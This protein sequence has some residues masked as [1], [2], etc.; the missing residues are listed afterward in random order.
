MT[1]FEALQRAAREGRLPPVVLLHGPE[2]LLRRRGLD[3]IVG[4]NRAVLVKIEGTETH[5]GRVADEL[6]GRSLFDPARVVAVMH[7]EEFI[8]SYRQRIE[9]YAEHPA[10]K[11]TLVIDSSESRAS[12]TAGPNLLAVSCAEATEETLVALA[13]QAFAARGVR[14]DRAACRELVRRLEDR[15]E[16][17]DVEVEKLSVAAGGKGRVEIADIEKH[18]E[19]GEQFE[20][21]DLV[22]AIA[23]GNRAEALRLA[24]R[25]LDQGVAMPMLLGGLAWHFRKLAEVRARIDGGME[26]ERAVYAAGVKF[27]AREFAEGA[28]RTSMAQIVESHR[29][30]VAFDL[31][32]KSS[33][34]A[35]DVLLERLVLELTR[36]SP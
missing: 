5:W 16:S 36:R 23:A 2:E 8:Q 31:A 11:A 14:I 6:H 4:A 29:A 22:N 27:R 1:P 15:R 9:S 12:L 17:L 32:I 35:E 18:V 19:D 20:G 7:A 3:L 24:H 34:A 21:F 13:E 30:L 26:P 33:A 10:Q 28:R 25:L